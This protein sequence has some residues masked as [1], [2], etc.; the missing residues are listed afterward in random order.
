M[1]AC[2]IVVAAPIPSFP[3]LFAEDCSFHWAA[4]DH[5]SHGRLHDIRWSLK[6]SSYFVRG[7]S[8][9]MT[10]LKAGKHFNLNHPSSELDVGMSV[11]V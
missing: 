11:A 4:V 9:C 1:S 3:P 7:V 2:C 5:A 6:L 10:R 8:N